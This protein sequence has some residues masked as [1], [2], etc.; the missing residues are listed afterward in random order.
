MLGGRW[1]LHHCGRERWPQ[2]HE[3]VANDC[4]HPPGFSNLVP[5]AWVASKEPHKNSKSKPKIT[6]L[7]AI[8]TLHTHELTTVNSSGLGPYPPVCVSNSTCLRAD[9]ENSNISSVNKSQA[10]SKKKPGGGLNE[11]AYSQPKA[12]HKHRPFRASGQTQ[13]TKAPTSNV[14]Q[15]VRR[16]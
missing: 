4:A 11:V 5:R 1:I 14:N 6:S 15:T 8:P 2:L 10:P 12:T 7:R 13:S 9:P 3:E 16:A